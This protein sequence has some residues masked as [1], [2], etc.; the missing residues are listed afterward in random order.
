MGI[1]ITN[2]H[3]IKKKIEAGKFVIMA[4]IEPPKGVNVSSMTANAT[5]LKGQVDAFMVPEM[6]SAVM[7]MSSLGGSFILHSIGLN[8][9]M[10][11]CCRDRNRL[12]LQAD[13]L[14]AYACG[15]STVMAIK[16]EDVNFGD[17]PKTKPV[18]DIELFELLNVLKKLQAG[19]DMSGVELAGAPKFLVGTTTNPSIY[20]IEDSSFEFEHEL[21]ELEQKYEAGAC[22]FITPPLF[23]LDSA[24]PFLEK[25]KHLKARIFPTVLLLKSLGMA[26]YIDRNIKHIHI[27][28]SVIERL[29]K[30]SDKEREGV[31]IAAELIDS[32]RQKGLGGI[33]ISTM[34]W[35]NKIPEILQ[36]LR[37]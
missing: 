12:A 37:R 24:N 25:A 26:R 15:I 4:E 16:G 6:S 3:H 31:K 17:H 35:E 32:F 18:Y 10:Q 34:G 36:N 22:F 13:L 8:T 5:K 11:I 20:N 27:P 28:S 23:D 1:T 2:H 7:R 9:V 19:R 21:E 29:K 33:L 14:A 30:S